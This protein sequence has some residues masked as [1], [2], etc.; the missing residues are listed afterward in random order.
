MKIFVT[1]HRGYIGS[2]LVDVLKQDGH[3]VVGCD[4]NLFEGCEWE[5]FAR[6]DRELVKDVRTIE[7]ADLDG[8]DCVMHLAAKILEVL[9]DPARAAQMGARAAARCEREFRPTAVAARLAASLRRARDR[10]AAGGA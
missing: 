7:P 4:L 5:A 2:H 3:S 6:P 8:C 1:G 9:S 10:A